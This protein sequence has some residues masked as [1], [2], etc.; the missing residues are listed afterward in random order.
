MPKTKTAKKEL[1]KSVRRRAHNTDRKRELKNS[2]KAARGAKGNDPKAIE[3]LAAAYKRLD[4]LAK[5][6]FIKKSKANR[7]KSRLAKQHARSAK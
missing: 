4:K 5:V 3:T 7:L 2:V 1:R 6:N